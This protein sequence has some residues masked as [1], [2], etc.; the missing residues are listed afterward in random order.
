MTSLSEPDK[1]IT[2]L[3]TLTFEQ[4]RLSASYSGIFFKLMWCFLLITGFTFVIKSYSAPSPSISLIL[5]LLGLLIAIPASFALVYR[6]FVTISKAPNRFVLERCLLN[7]RF[8]FSTTQ[9]DFDQ[10]CKITVASGYFSR[11]GELY[12]VYISGS[13]HGNQ[14]SYLVDSYTDIKKAEILAEKL[15]IIIHT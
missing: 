8:K 10:N 5:L 15:H 14:A 7:H 4:N 9:V 11:T 1:K 12:S 6:V 3:D 13:H 2:N